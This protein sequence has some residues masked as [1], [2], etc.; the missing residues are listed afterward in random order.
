MARAEA[1]HRKGTEWVCSSLAVGRAIFSSQ[2]GAWI[3]EGESSEILYTYAA[4]D[5][6]L[7]GMIAAMQERASAEDVVRLAMA[8][9]WE[10]AGHPEKFPRNRACVEELTPR[11]LL[12]KID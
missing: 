9:N 1:L 12:T 5:A 7:A 11:V 6:L 2:K 4:E 10:C 3:A 8:C